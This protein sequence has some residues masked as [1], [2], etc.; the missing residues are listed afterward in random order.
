[1]AENKLSQS[2]VLLMAVAGGI[3]VANIYYNQPILKDIQESIHSTE[4]QARCTYC[5]N[6]YS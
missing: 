5:R 2:Q 3:A 6:I 4:A 1:M